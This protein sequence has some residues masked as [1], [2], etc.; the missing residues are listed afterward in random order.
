[1]SSHEKGQ[2][3]NKFLNLESEAQRQANT[4]TNATVPAVDPCPV[5]CLVVY[6]LSGLSGLILFPSPG[7]S[8]DAIVPVSPPVEQYRN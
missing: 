5:R 8:L 4:S 7:L 3:L 2:K 1:M 6:C